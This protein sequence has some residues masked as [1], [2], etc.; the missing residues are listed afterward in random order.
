MCSNAHFDSAAASYDELASRLARPF[1]LDALVLSGLTN[2][3]AGARDVIDIAAGTGAFSIPAAKHGHRVVATDISPPMLAQLEQRRG[4]DDY[5]QTLVGDA[6]TLHQ[7][8]TAAYDVA[9]SM[10]GIF[11]VPNRQS[12]WKATHR[13]LRDNGIIVASS[14]HLNAEC[15]TN[16][17]T[18]YCSLLDRFDELRHVG[19]AEVVSND[20][21]MLSD[22]GKFREEL[23]GAG[24]VDIKLHH[25]T[26]AAAFE[27]LQLLFQILVK[28]FEPTRTIYAR[29]NSMQQKALFAG[30]ASSFSSSSDV[31]TYR[32]Q[33][34]VLHA[35]AW[36]AVARKPSI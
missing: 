1:S 36:I 29:C 12:A 7:V 4:K 3:D 24:F 8:Q 28:M 13:V 5:P 34:I 16:F 9:V 26:H 27:S 6:Q 22:P 21:T 17:H 18:A 15:A 25:L 14:W 2:R 19:D 11:L 33:A 30:F 10:F 20:W 35:S 31:S 23:S 32:N